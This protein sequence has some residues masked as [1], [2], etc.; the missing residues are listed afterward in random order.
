M[1]VSVHNVSASEQ[2]KQDE[3]SSVQV[4]SKFVAV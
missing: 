3:S 4:E 1:N 2:Y